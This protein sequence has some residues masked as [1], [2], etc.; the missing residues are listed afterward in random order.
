[1]TYGA[2]NGPQVKLYTSHASRRQVLGINNINNDNNNNNNKRPDGLTLVLWQSGHCATWDVTVVHTLAASCG[3][4]VGQ[5]DCQVQQP[6]IEPL[7]LPCGC[8]DSWRTGWWWTH[9]HSGDWQESCTK[10]RSSTN[11]SRLRFSDLTQ[12][13]WPTHFQFPS[14]QGNHSKDFTDLL[15]FYAPGNEVPVG[16]KIIIIIT[17][18][19]FMVLYVITK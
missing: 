16:Q 9:V 13:A 5:E 17:E 11:A 10:P 4:R 12:Y 3:S 15:S 8:R 7:V 1:M 19:I 14:P 18:I 6:V 2:A